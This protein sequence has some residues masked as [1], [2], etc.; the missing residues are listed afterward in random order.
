MLEGRNEEEA[1]RG[2]CFCFVFKKEKKP[3]DKKRMIQRKGPSTAR[4]ML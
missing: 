2:V 1:G 3:I 4:G